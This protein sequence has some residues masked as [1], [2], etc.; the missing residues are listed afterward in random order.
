MSLTNFAALTDENYTVW[1][2]DFWREA[3]NKTFLMDFVGTSENSMIQRVDELRQT[4]DGARAVITLINEAQGDGVVGDNELDGNEEAMAS[5]DFVIQLDQWR[6]AH[7]S[8]GRMAEQKSI[9]RFREEARGTLSTRA[10]NVIDQLLF[11]TLTGVDY[12]MNTDGTPRSGGSQLPQLSFNADV[13]APTSRRHFRWDA[14]GGLLDSSDGT[15]A[16]S[17]LAAG[18]TPSW[19]MLVEMKAKAVNEFIKPIRSEGGIEMYN[20][21]MTPDGIKALKKD[22]NFLE[23][24]KH[25]QQRGESNPIFK[26]TKHGGRKGIMIDGLNILEYRHVYHASNWGG[27]SQ[28]GQAALLCGAQALAWADINGHLPK[29]VEDLKDYKNRLGVSIGKIFGIRKPFLYSSHAQSVQDFGVIRVDT[30]V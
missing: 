27:G 18:D 2:R 29:W 19:E 5:D 13:S 28:K 24:W 14:T 7:S 17:N 8:K 23:A 30:S 1:G 20:V 22:T 9:I 6:H 21:F 11:L 26:G 16:V 4:N 15:F 12:S 25:A 3:R 10:A